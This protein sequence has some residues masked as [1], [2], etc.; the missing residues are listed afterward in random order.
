MNALP[1]LAPFVLIGLFLYWRLRN[2][3]VRI[4]PHR[5]NDANDNFLATLG[6]LG[7]VALAALGVFFVIVPDAEGHRWNP[8]LY[9]PASLLVAGLGIV[10][11]YLRIREHRFARAG[12]LVVSEWPLVPGRSVEL[13]FE[14]VANSQRSPHAAANSH[15]SGSIWIDGT[16]SLFE[17]RGRLGTRWE[18]RRTT[19]LPA[20]APSLE[21]G[22]ARARF[23]L[24][25][26]DD[27]VPRRRFFGLP[28][29][30]R[31]YRWEVHLTVSGLE[32]HKLESTF[33]L[34]FAH[35]P[36]RDSAARS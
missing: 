26:P 11:L 1:L 25:V 13:S 23:R 21:G 2:P 33:H 8:Y 35:A 15:A 7:L 3:S 10:R 16:L 9:G 28:T 14:R 34:A 32:G 5:C 4:G 19:E 22:T 12:T 31:D 30:P 17:A 20:G 29:P 27:A 36:E 24:T 18:L 6:S